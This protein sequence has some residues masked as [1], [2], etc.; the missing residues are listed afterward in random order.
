VY[1]LE[2]FPGFFDADQI[3]LL[4]EAD[5]PPTSRI[6]FDLG[7]AVAE[8][9]S[10]GFIHGD[11]HSGNLYYDGT[12]HTYTPID[13]A[14]SV[15]Y[16][17]PLMKGSP[18]AGGVQLDPTKLSPDLTLVD[19]VAM[20]SS[21]CKI[22][23]NEF[24]AF[25][26]GY[27]KASQKLIDPVAVAYTERL[28][29]IVGGR[30][31]SPCA[32]LPIHGPTSEVFTA[33]ATARSHADL[34]ALAAQLDVG[35]RIAVALAKEILSAL[36][37]EHP[38]LDELHGQLHGTDDAEAHRRHG[39]EGPTAESSLPSE[40][41]RHRW[42]RNIRQALTR[43][44][45]SVVR[46]KQDASVKPFELIQA[47]DTIARTIADDSRPKWAEF[48]E[49]TC[50]V[51]VGLLG[52]KSNAAALTGGH[53]TF[54]TS[55]YQAIQI[56]FQILLRNEN[57]TE[58]ERKHLYVRQQATLLRHR[59]TGDPNCW[60][61]CCKA[62]EIGFGE[63]ACLNTEAFTETCVFRASAEELGL[64]SPFWSSAFDARSIFQCAARYL[65]DQL[66]Q[67][68]RDESSIESALQMGKILFGNYAALLRRMLIEAQIQLSAP[69]RE[70]WEES[71]PDDSPSVRGEFDR[72][73]QIA[74]AFAQGFDLDSD[75]PRFHTTVRRIC[76]R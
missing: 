13:L 73:A 70:F 76:R 65:L 11:L 21:I 6:S 28:L 48:L 44:R 34:E 32:P 30:I 24:L 62:S 67:R 14:T 38:P 40:D 26:G 51:L 71:G 39:V 45:E 46:N 25:I 33:I 58:L 12:R 50:E 64:P 10:V 60:S 63:I 9:H 18:D 16:W 23:P 72:I 55:T 61:A 35:E 66:V 54:L 69:Y 31:A 2:N 43:E 53:R 27:T 20:H 5:C 52:L 42:A 74:D 56:L 59:L 17:I 36:N 49:T 68:E 57:A 8:L 75:L 47:L 4:C 22:S 7:T 37:I 3:L 29:R 15:D 19:L 41:E 1:S